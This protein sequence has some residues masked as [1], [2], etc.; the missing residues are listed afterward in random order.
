VAPVAKPTGLTIPA[1]DVQVDQLMELG[2]SPE[3]KMQTPDDAVT[4]GWYDRLPLSV[5]AP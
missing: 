5:V 3:G 1:I 2:V 4:I